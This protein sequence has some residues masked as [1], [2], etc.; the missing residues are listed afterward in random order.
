MTGLQI[1]W[2][3]LGRL[4]LAELLR[5]LFVNPASVTHR[6]NPN[7]TMVLINNIDDTKSPHAVFP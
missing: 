4:R 1:S 7:E 6:D 2:E 3:L 5:R